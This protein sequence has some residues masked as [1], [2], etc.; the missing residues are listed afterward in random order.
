VSKSGV[1]RPWERKFLG[2]RISPEGK[3]GI[4]P[5]SVERFLGKVREMWRIAR[6]P[7]LHKALSNVVVSGR[8]PR[9]PTRS[10]LE[11]ARSADVLV[12]S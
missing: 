6:S 12:A 3:I 5:Q 10:S 11:G 7:S 4:A 8:N 1:G 9:H 2:F